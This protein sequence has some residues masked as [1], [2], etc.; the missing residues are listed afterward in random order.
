MFYQVSRI[1]YIDRFK[2]VGP[3]LRY[4]YKTNR[5]ATNVRQ[6]V[7]IF[8]VFLVAYGVAFQSLIYPGIEHSVPTFVWGF[9]LRP[10][11]EMLGEP[12]FEDF[13]ANCLITQSDKG[14][15]F[16]PQ[17]LIIFFLKNQACDSNL[18]TKLLW[19]P[20]TNIWNV[21]FFGVN[22]SSR[23]PQQT[24]TAN[25]SGFRNHRRVPQL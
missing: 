4:Y 19:I 2:T 9:F 11:F 13:S 14:S 21:I 10:F 22:V 20:R 24:N 18:L 1:K 5:I 8:S 7:I 3:S 23:L 15:K 17:F 25:C 6:S 12:Q 16:N